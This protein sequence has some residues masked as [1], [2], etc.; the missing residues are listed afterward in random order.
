MALVMYYKLGQ[1]IFTCQRKMRW[2]VMTRIADDTGPPHWPFSPSS[3]LLTSISRILTSLVISQHSPKAMMFFKELCHSKTA[4][5][6][7]VEFTKQ[8]RYQI[9]VHKICYLDIYL[10][11]NLHF[12][13]VNICEIKHYSA[14]AAAVITPQ[15]IILK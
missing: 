10:L 7:Q 9:R 11:Y 5:Q 15:W 4:N 1:F 12:S 2:G 13:E 6:I 8:T 14:Y 3:D